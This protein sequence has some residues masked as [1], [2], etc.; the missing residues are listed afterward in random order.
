MERENKFRNFVFIALFLLFSSCTH[1]PTIF[2]SK[3][4]RAGSKS[5]R[6]R[7]AL[8]LQKRNILGNKTK[9]EIVELLGPPDEGSDN[10][11]GYEVVT[12]SRCYFWTCRMEIEFDLAT[13]KSVGKISISD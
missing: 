10:W 12:L 1:S 6:G 3:T 7:M 13:Q 11:Y 8:D 4:W 2:E 5:T 9:G